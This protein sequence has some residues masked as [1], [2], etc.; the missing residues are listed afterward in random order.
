MG[1][2]YRRLVTM[3]LPQVIL[4]LAASLPRHYALKFAQGQDDVA[5]PRS[6]DEILS[7]KTHHKTGTFLA[8]QLAS[9]VQRVG[10]RKHVKHPGA[11]RGF[12]W[13]GTGLG[14]SERAVHFVRSPSHLARSAYLYHK[15]FPPVEKHLKL[16]A[17]WPAELE[18]CSKAQSYPPLLRENRQAY[19][20][21]VPADVGLLM[22]M[23]TYGG[24]TLREMDQ[25][26]RATGSDPRVLTVCLEQSFSDFDG[27]MQQI[28]DHLELA[29]S[30]KLL[31]CF[32]KQNPSTFSFG[33]HTTSGS[34]AKGEDENL[35]RTIKSEDHAF[36]GD[37]YASSEAALKC[38]AGA[39]YRDSS[40]DNSMEYLHYMS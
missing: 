3:Q 21:R 10:Q 28:V 31:R 4:L 36:F 18:N 29:K 35:L 13:D 9:C 38:A 7:F 24:T 19:L 32:G 1:T 20:A 22:T 27:L 33:T 2:S 8:E 12:H 30:D 15:Q 17:K 14:P 25:A 23:A 40:A 37:M 5:A 26:M 39:P 34:V 11:D 16:P 6:Q